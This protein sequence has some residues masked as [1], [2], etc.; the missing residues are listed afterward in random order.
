MCCICQ[1]VNHELDS[2]LPTGVTALEKA[3][4][5]QRPTAST[6]VSSFDHRR[7]HDSD[8]VSFQQEETLAS[9]FPGTDHLLPDA[10]G[11]TV[12]GGR[13]EVASAYNFDAVDIDMFVVVP[14]VEEGC[15]FSMGRVV[16]VVTA[17]ECFD[18]PPHVIFEVWKV[19]RSADHNDRPNIFGRWSRMKAAANVEAAKK[20]KLNGVDILLSECSLERILVWPIQ[21]E[22]DDAHKDGRVR[23]K[24]T[25]LLPFSVF[26]FMFLLHKLDFRGTQHAFTTRGQEYVQH[27]S[28]RL[29]AE[30]GL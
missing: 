14:S 16:R 8:M 7:A 23:T 29:S 25:A 9:T 6:R 19:K 20:R 27:L 17:E 21:V 1:I 11:F 15:P 22:A 24:D 2:Y 4:I 12:S 18:L 28:R 5:L 3:R 13:G 26:D 10:R 30:P